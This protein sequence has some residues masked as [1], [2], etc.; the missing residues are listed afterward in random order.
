[1]QTFLFV[2]VILTLSPPIPLRLYTLPYCSNP[3][4]LPRD[5]MLARYQLS[6]CV[7]PSVCLSVTSRSCT[8]MAKPR[9]RLTTP[10]DSP[11][12]LVFRRQN[13]WRNSHDI[14]PNGGAKQRWGK[15]RSALCGQYLAILRNGARQGHSYYG[16]LIGTRTLSIEW[17]Y[18]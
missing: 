2:P 8:K 15:F 10:Y 11:E 14:T 7:C 4:F 18:F 12:T 9:I 16:K 5:A 1:M 17:R 13:S 6:S 3:P